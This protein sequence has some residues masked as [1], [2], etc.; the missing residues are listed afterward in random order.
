MKARQCAPD[1]SNFNQHRLIGWGDEYS[2]L[3]TAQWFHEATQREPLWMRAS[4]VRLQIDAVVAG[5]GLGALPKFIADRYNLVEINAN[6]FPSTDAEIWLL[7]SQAS[8]DLPHVK[9][10]ASWIEKIVSANKSV[11]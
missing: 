3:S 8:K 5:L 10:V 11:L 9:T 6:G 1:I 2:H 4:N 7:R